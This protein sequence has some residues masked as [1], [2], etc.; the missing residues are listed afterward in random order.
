MARDAGF[1]RL[2]PAR[3][4]PP[5]QR[6]L[7]DP[8][9]RL[10]PAA[11]RR[12]CGCQRSGAAAY[13]AL[14]ATRSSTEPYRRRISSATRSGGATTATAWRRSSWTTLAMPAQ[15][16]DRVRSRRRG[17]RSPQPWTSS[18]DL[19][20]GGRRV[21]A[22]LAAHRADGRL[23]RGVVLARGDHD[24]QRRSRSVA[25]RAPGRARPRSRAGRVTSCSDR[26][27]QNGWTMKPSA[28]SPA[29][30]VIAGPDAAQPD[31]GRADVE[32]TRV[33][34]RRHQRVRVV[35]ALEAERRAVLPRRP[36]GADGQ[37]Q[38]AHPGRRRRPRHREAPLDVGL[39]L[40]PEPEVE[41]SARQR[42]QVPRLVGEGHRVPGERD[43]DR[44]RELEPLGGVR[45]QHQR[46][47]R[48]VRALEGE[49]AVVAG[50]LHGSSRVGRRRRERT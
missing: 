29:A 50:R 23:H 7:R 43:G 17:W 20:G 2:P 16:P 30:S 47:E 26:S 32:R 5:D 1:T 27:V 12:R 34:E 18:D 14:R 49:G 11:G 38:L 33:E 35:V 31:A 8:S 36:D 40:A 45:G 25:G 10:R 6:L 9:V 41:A 46:Q 15:S 19:V 21:E 37:H 4:R 39:D 24:R 42:L 48:V 22:D 28:T 44:G 13:G 3:G